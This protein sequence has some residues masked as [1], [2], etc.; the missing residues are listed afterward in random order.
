MIMSWGR[1]FSGGGFPVFLIPF[2]A[3]EMKKVACSRCPGPDQNGPQV[4]TPLKVLRGLAIHFVFLGGYLNSHGHSCCQFLLAFCNL[5]GSNNTFPG[6]ELL[7]PSFA[8]KYYSGNNIPEMGIGVFH[9]PIPGYS[10]NHNS[11]N[12]GNMAHNMVGGTMMAPTIPY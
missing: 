5:A 12:Y 9:L 4:R 8:G 7:Y 11:H 1:M 3:E 10:C 6:P 2:V